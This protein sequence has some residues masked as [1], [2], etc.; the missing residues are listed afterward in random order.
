METLSFIQ[1]IKLLGMQAAAAASSVTARS[2]DL[3]QLLEIRSP[4]R[5]RYIQRPCSTQP[6]DA[7]P[8]QGCQVSYFY[9]GGGW[10]FREFVGNCIQSTLEGIEKY[11]TLATLAAFPSSVGWARNRLGTSVYGRHQTLFPQRAGVSQVN[12]SIYFRRSAFIIFPTRPPL[13]PRVFFLSCT[14]RVRRFG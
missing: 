6:Q 8:A 5:H 3:H 1:A 14:A 13:P 11:C 7:L 9:H 10:F 12:S 2:T 4:I